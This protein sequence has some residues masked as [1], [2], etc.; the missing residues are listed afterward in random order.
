MTKQG[1]VQIQNYLS[2]DEYANMLEKHTQ[3]KEFDLTHITNVFDELKEYDFEVINTTPYFDQVKMFIRGAVTRIGAYSNMGKT[4][5]ANGVVCEMLK[6]GYT[7]IVFSVEVQREKVLSDLVSNLDNVDPWKVLKKLHTPTIATKKILEGLQIYD[8]RHGALYLANIRDYVIAN[9]G[10]IDFIMIDF[11][12]NIKDYQCSR[13]EYE[14]LSNYA[15]EVQQLAQQMDVCIIDLSQLAN[16][17]IK[18]DF[19]KTGFIAYKGSGGLYAS[20]DI[21]IQLI[22]DKINSPDILDVQVRK[23]KFYMTG[24]IQVKIDLA[25]SKFEYHQPSPTDDTHDN[26]ENYKVRL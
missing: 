19:K 1:Q 23:H 24:D 26:T 3:N 15:L 7:G 16:S 12:Q 6:K 10:N 17:S 25:K 20:G 8:G 4:K 5:F 18:E 21:G 22:R 2:S 9:K 14:R 13:D 11:C